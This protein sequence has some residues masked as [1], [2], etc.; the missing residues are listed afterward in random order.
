MTELSV[1][2]HVSKP[3]HTG[4]RLAS[5][6]PCMEKQ[7]KKKKK[8]QRL[9]TESDSTSCEIHWEGVNVNNWRM[10]LICFLDARERA[11]PGYLKQAVVLLA[12]T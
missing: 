9:V 12:C 1:V 3:Q 5:L 7:T 8:S 2:E 10:N 4:G 11:A 6:M